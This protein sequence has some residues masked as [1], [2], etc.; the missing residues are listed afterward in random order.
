MLQPAEDFNVGH[1]AVAADDSR[2]VLHRRKKCDLSIHRDNLVIIQAQLIAVPLHLL[3]PGTQQ[4][5]VGGLSE[6]RELGGLWRREDPGF[7]AERLDVCSSPLARSWLNRSDALR[8][9]Q[10]V[11][12]HA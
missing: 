12:D 4:A 9:V 10:E 8:L 6:L 7:H 1:D 3:G 11:L 5:E 2:E